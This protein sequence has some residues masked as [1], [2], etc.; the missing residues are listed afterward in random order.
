[1]PLVLWYPWSF[2]QL[3]SQ[4]PSSLNRIESAIDRAASVQTQEIRLDIGLL[5]EGPVTEFTIKGE[6]FTRAL[7][8]LANAANQIGQS[9]A[10]NGAEEDA[11]SLLQIAH[12]FARFANPSQAPNAPMRTAL[13]SA[14]GI[15]TRLSIS[16]IKA[17]SFDAGQ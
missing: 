9:F 7:F 5:R 17:G 2:P 3:I 11:L 15:Q 8:S 4:F 14:I 10:D 1:M 12:E 13:Q 6:R 16:E